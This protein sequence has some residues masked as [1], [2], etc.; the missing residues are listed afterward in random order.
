MDFASLL[1]AQIAASKPVGQSPSSAL[2]S[3][4]TTSSSPKPTFVSEEQL[5]R[6]KLDK[7]RKL[8]E[9]EAQRDLVR[10]EKKRR[11]AEESRIRIAE[12]EKAIEAARRKRLGLPDLPIANIDADDDNDQG[13]LG[14]DIPEE[15]LEAK[16]R[17]LSEP[18]TLFGEDHVAKLKRYRR[19]LN[20]NKNQPVW[21][22]GPI[23][24]TIPL[25]EEVD[26]KVPDVL[27][28]DKDKKGKDKLFGQLASYFTM[29][30]TEWQSALSRRE[31]S[32]KTS[33][34]GKAAYHNM[35]QAKDS[36]VPLF[37]KMEQ[38]DL[39]KGIL[40]PVVEIV[41]YCQARKYV[42]A[43][44]AYLRLS[45]GKAAWPIGVTMV[46]IHE[47][48]A[49]EKLHGNDKNAAHIMSDETTRKYLQG[50]KRCL[51]FAQTRWPPDD[52]MQLMG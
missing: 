29:I 50:I 23:P 1:S 5:R 21:S 10:Q 41:R 40:E 42:S 14:E 3:P 13:D 15:D 33:T 8:E 11:L 38:G 17:E 47:R 51:T 49:R 16:L 34:T 46:G 18:V 35:I 4:S 31:G 36:M 32:V 52:Q 37:R 25:V 20:I 6:E 24:T 45:I 12:E 27:P 26:M 44:D 9:D 30:F 43:N 48:S 39:D 19:L 28:A 2:A 22:N 7:K